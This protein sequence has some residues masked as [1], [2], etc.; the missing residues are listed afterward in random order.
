MDNYS[1]ESIQLISDIL[2]ESERDAQW[3]LNCQEVID[4]HCKSGYKLPKMGHH[5]KVTVVEV[6]FLN[7]QD[8][9]RRQRLLNLPTSFKLSKEEVDEL[10][11]VGGELLMQSEAFNELLKRI[12]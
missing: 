12:Q 1:F 5:F 3:I 11:S 6:N 10:I 2:E 4:E 7:I 8:V 9:E